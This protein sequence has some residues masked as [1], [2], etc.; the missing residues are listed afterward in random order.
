MKL[1]D[2]VKDLGL[3]PKL[4]CFSPALARLAGGIPH[5]ALL[6]HVLYRASRSGSLDAWVRR[7]HEELSSDIGLSRRVLI[8]VRRDLKR[9]GLMR[10][11][12]VSIGSAVEYQVCLEVLEDLLARG[13]RDDEADLQRADRAMG[14]R[15]SRDAQRADRAMH[16]EEARGSEEQLEPLAEAAARLGTPAASSEG[17]RPRDLVW[18]ALVEV[19]GIAEAEITKSQRGALNAAVRQLKDVGA[20]PEEIHRRGA[21]YRR[22]H[23][24]WPLTGTALAKHWPFLTEETVPAPSNGHGF[25]NPPDR[26]VYRDARIA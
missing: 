2:I 3:E 8:T 21:A 16:K 18:D 22:R 25:R 13:S 4:C 20:T 1:T 12:R 23:P 10:E 19:L 17:P 7:T 14:A 6:C 15:G 9:S 26:A 5:G 11:R 24:E